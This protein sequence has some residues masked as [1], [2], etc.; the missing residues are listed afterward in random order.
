MNDK[1]E[2]DPEMEQLN[3]VLNK[4]VDIQHPE[5]IKD[6]IREK[7]IRNKQEVFPVQIFDKN[8]IVSLMQ[9]DRISD[10]VSKKQFSRNSFYN[11][12]NDHDNKVTESRAIE[13]VIHESQTVVSG[14]TV[15]L[16]IIND[17]YI[18]G[19]LIPKNNFIFGMTSLEN[20]RLGIRINSVRY[21]SNLLPVALEVY[22]LDGLAGIYI[23]GSMSRDVAKSS[24]E[25]GLQNVE[26]STLNPSLAAQA[27]TAGIQATKNLLT[28]KVKLIK[29]NLKAGY[30]VLLKDNN[31]N[32]N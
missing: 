31:K 2:S 7:S 13:A 26:L 29:V 10:T 18:N 22:D 32:N 8:G 23:P 20:D 14:S 24:A 15:K 21:E 17:I 11:L 3:T 19:V 9:P 16:R 12:N 28:R 25:L 27:T 1:Q 4:I 6:S 30:K 5:R